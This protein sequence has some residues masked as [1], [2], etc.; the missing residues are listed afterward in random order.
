MIKA[1]YLKIINKIYSLIRSTH[2]QNRLIVLFV[3]LSLLPMLITGIYSYHKSSEAIYDKINTY[4]L[5]VVNQIAKNINEELRRMQYQSIE[6]AFSDLVQN[7]MRNYDKLSDWQIYDARFK[8]RDEMVRKFS[9]SEYISDVQLFTDQGQKIIAYGDTGFTLNFKDKF[10]EK[11]LADI[12][13]ADGGAVWQAVDFRD[14]FHQVD[15]IYAPDTSGRSYGILIGR[16][17]KD[18]YQGSQLGT[19]LIRVNENIFSDIYRNINLGQGA[20][21]FILNQA[22]TVVSTRNAKLRFNQPYPDNNLIG[23]IKAQQQKKSYQQTFKISLENEPYL[24][25]YSVIKDTNWYIVSTIPFSY[26]NKETSL[27]RK[28]IIILGLLIFILALGFSYIF[29]K[30]I[31]N[32]LNKLVIAMNKVEAGDLNIKLKD[33]SQDELAEVSGNFNMMVSEL[34][35]LLADIKEKE[36]QKNELEFK[37]LQAQINP[38]FLANILNTARLLADMQNV[39]NLE[40][41]LASIINLLHL[42]MNN[43]ESFISVEREIEYLKSYLNIQ[44]FRLHNKFEVHF[45]I[46][47]EILDNK[48]PKFILQPIVENSII[49]GISNKNGQGLIMIKG[50]QEAN[51]II[52]S[53]TDDGIGM[54]ETEIKKLLTENET[55]KDHFSG[56]GIKNV[57]ERI[58]LYFGP[59][60]GVEIESLKGYFT[61]VTI[62]LAE[63]E[64]DYY[65][66]SDDR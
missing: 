6:V 13:E 2:I 7:T 36:K 38:H 24:A 10:R 45:E 66:E 56:I 57:K 3:L 53:V 22:G 12:K 59:E 25:A 47:T 58:E 29:T 60:Y 51:K 20:E 30:S 34:E 19:V 55:G 11:L 62:K 61:T 31:S 17:I 50:Y 64:R 65:A 16:I 54:T 44:Q 26:L 39:D 28:E 46:E 14:E 49:H 32:P 23:R 18:L 5:E 9:F 43:K 27:I 21:I 1:V 63:L 33:N 41:F 37:A 4:S 52:F 48:I 8:I 40:N 42:S 15:R 35:S